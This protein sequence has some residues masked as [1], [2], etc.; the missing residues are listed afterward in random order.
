MTSGNSIIVTFAMVDEYGT[1]TC[2]DSSGSNTYNVDVDQRQTNQTRV[3]ICS[4]H[5][6]TALSTSDSITV[7]H[8]DTSDRAMS[9]VEFSG[10]ATSVTPLDQIN[11]N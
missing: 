9:V 8:P 6:V 3:V 11:S 10:L 5:N 2:T 4:A 1:I 7:N